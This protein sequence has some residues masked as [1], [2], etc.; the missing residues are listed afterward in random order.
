MGFIY[1]CFFIKDS[2]LVSLDDSI[3]IINEVLYL[4]FYEN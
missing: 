1:L 3:I 4:K 2:I